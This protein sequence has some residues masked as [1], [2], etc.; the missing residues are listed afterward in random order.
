VPRSVIFDL[1]Y[2]LCAGDEVGA[3]LYEPVFASIRRANAGAL[4]EAAL[5]E[6]FAAC[7]RFPFDVVAERFQFSAAMYRAG[8]RVFEAT[9][10]AVPL[11]GY[12]D[13]HVLRD[14]RARCFLVTSGFP[15]LQQSKITALGIRPCFDAIDVDS[16][17]DHPRRRKQTIFADIVRR[18]GLV[19]RKVWVVGDNGESEIAAG[20]RLGMTTVQILRPGVERCDTARHTVRNLIE[21]KALMDSSAGP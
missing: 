5:A 3:T 13:L 14:L 7:M 1:D 20:N 4:T 16:I 17:V 2:C 12:P 6:A 10:V 15:R 11:H 21:L 9:E 8:L 19:S 18:Y